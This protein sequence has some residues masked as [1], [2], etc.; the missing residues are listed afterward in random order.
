[1]QAGGHRFDPVHLH[2]GF[3]REKFFGEFITKRCVYL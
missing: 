3:F 1:L 2:Q